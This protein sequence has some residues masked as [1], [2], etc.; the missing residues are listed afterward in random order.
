MSAFVH[1]DEALAAIEEMAS[2]AL[3]GLPSLA[4]VLVVAD[5]FGRLRLVLWGEDSSVLRFGADLEARL[6]ERCGAWWSGAVLRGDEQAMIWEPAWEEARTLRGDRRLRVLARHRSRTS[7][8]VDTDPV[9]RWS[10][11]QEET[12]GPPVVSFYSFKGGL[13]RSTTLAS[14]AIQR[15]RRGERV[16]VVDFDLDAPG[17]GTLLAAD[18][19]GVTARWG[20]VDYLLERPRGAVPLED[21]YHRCARVA[22]DGE[23][24]VFPAGR[25]D[26]AYLDKLARV[27]LEEPSSDPEAWIVQGLLREIRAALRPDWILLDARTGVSEPAGRLLSGLAHLHVLFGTTSAQSW[28]GLA[29]ALDRLGRDRVLRGEPQAEVLL[30]QAMVPASDGPRDEAEREFRGRAEQEFTDRYF[31]PSGS[32]ERFW[33]VDDLDSGDGPHSPVSLTYRDEF[34][35]FS[36][37]SRI[38]DALCEREHAVV[39]AR[40]ADRFLRDEPEEPG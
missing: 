21:Y 16:V 5:L 33:S 28:Q 30:V 37:I 8:F 1:F 14:F 9:W 22:G 20:I 17:L 25:V 26:E 15:A 10:P 11:R 31:A 24:L 3:C 19:H 27:D 39:A 4:R 6:G 40:I 2:D 29:R 13:G 7:W 32:E 36:D 34:A 23:I 38:A 18:E 12:E 35:H